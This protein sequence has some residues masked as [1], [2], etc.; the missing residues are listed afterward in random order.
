MPDQ[1]DLLIRCFATNM[2]ETDNQ[3]L[4]EIDGISIAKQFRGKVGKEE[5]GIG[6]R[7]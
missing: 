2:V 3:I 5:I 4:R 1:D 7:G 6:H